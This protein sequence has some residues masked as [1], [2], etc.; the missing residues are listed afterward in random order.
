MMCNKDDPMPILAAQPAFYPAY[1][2]D[3]PT[4]HDSTDRVWTVLH[5]RPR[6]EK[7]LAQHLW[8]INIPFYVPQIARPVRIR[9]RIVHSHLPL[10]PGYLFLLGSRDDRLA[11]LETGRVVQT[12]KVI[13]QEGLWNDLRQI[14]RL[15]ASGAPLTPEGPLVAGATVE[16]R[17]GPLA[18]LRGTII[19]SVSGRRFLVRVDFIQRGASVLLDDIGLVKIPD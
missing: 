16:I 6:Q 5:T 13:D 9:S 12:L 11:A 10:F 1:L 14:Q 18:G 7:R 17:S 4:M 8:N 19:Q 3:E 2:F 15:I